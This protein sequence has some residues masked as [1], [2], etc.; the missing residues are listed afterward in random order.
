M[1]HKKQH[2]VPATYLRAWCDVDSPSDYEPY[3]W[4]FPKNGGEPKRK[5]PEKIFWEPDFYTIKKINGKRDLV[6][7]HGLAQLESQFAVLRDKKLSKRKPLTLQD[8]SILCTF[9]AAMY[10]RTKARRNHLQGQWQQVLDMGNRMAEWVKTASPEQVKQL[11]SAIHTPHEKESSLSM[12]DI[13]YIV[14][15][16]IQSSLGA[17]IGIIAPA[18]LNMQFAVLDTLATPIFLTSDN[19]CVWVDPDLP[20]E[21]S[22]F[23]VEGISLFS[24]SIEI[25]L[26]LSPTQ[27]IFFGRKLIVSNFYIPIQVANPLTDTLNNRTWVYSNEFF[28]NNQ[29][30]VKFSWLTKNSA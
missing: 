8:K 19:P 20:K 26:P 5:P 16:T 6:L 23:G 14:E 2:F 28:V 22:K 27:C 24:P 10:A 21:N 15:N 11:S 12:A 7:E 4:V 9:T 1:H 13:E 17:E 25:S 18:L 3:V 30:T 29:R